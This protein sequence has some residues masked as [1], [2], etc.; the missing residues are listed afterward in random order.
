M[1]HD[2]HVPMGVVLGKRGVRRRNHGDGVSA[3]HSW[4]AIFNVLG[5]NTSKK[6][7][8]ISETAQCEKEPLPIQRLCG[9]YPGESSLH[10]AA[11]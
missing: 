11:V 1:T 5:A 3:S 2:A 6:E 7:V 8:D 9:N 4:G 10:A